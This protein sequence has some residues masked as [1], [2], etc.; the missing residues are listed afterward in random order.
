MGKN[1][2]NKQGLNME[3]M[4]YYVNMDFTYLQM[5]ATCYYFLCISCNGKK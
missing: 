5:G 3:R 1:N 4:L 2:K